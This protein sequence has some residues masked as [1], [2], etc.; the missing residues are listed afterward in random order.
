MSKIPVFVSCPTILNKR[1]KA[2]R[3]IIIDIIDDLNMEPRALGR[4]DYPKDFPLKEIAILCKRCSGGIILGFEQTKVIIGEIKR[5]TKEEKTIKEKSLP[6]PWNNIEAGI[7][8]GLKLPLLIFKEKEISGGV[9]D[10]GISDA[11]I[12]DF[13]QKITEAKKNEIKQ[14]VQKWFAEV[15]VLH[16]I[17]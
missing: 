16:N 3:K 6:T 4:S 12:H 5:G 7:L 8:F 15:S 11:F 14:V 13:P 2:Y 17:F 9:F 10:Y 1:Q